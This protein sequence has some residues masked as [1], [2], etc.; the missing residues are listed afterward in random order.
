M[1]G[2]TYD[3]IVRRFALAA[4]SGAMLFQL[5]SCDAGDVQAQA[6]RGL[7]TTIDGLFHIFAQ[8]FANRVFGVDD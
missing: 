4:L 5:G 7:T 1:N 8:D 6:A 2:R 3:K